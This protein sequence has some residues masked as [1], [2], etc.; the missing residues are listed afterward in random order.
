MLNDPRPT[1]PRRP[2]IVLAGGGH[3]NLHALRRAADLVGSGFDVTLVNPSPYLYYSGMATGTVS[4]D[5]GPHAHRIDVR[6]LAECG[7]GRF[8]EGKIKRIAERHLVL[9]GGG[10]VPFDAASATVGSET[11]FPSFARGADSVF[12]AKPIE[13]L[14]GLRRALLERAEP[15]VLVVGGGAA[16]CEISANALALLARDGKEGSVTLVERGGR[17]LPDAPEGAGRYVES[18]LRLRGARV[19]TGT[20]V[21]DLG[22]GVAHTGDGRELPCDVAVLA[23]G[24]VP[25]TDVFRA[26]GLPVGDDG[27]LWVDG[28]LRSL[29]NGRLFGGGDSISLHGTGLPRLGIF[30]IRQGPVIHH[31]LKAVLRGE[32]LREFRP[33]NRY[34]YVLNLGD[35]TGLAVYGDLWWRGRLA[36]RIKY[37]IDGRF[38]SRNSPRPSGYR[39]PTPSSKKSTK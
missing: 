1:G 23:T 22:G 30:A 4:G 33:Q 11:P 28:S 36:Y 7:G 15:R 20:A 38:V 14:G 13:G 37:L 25:P 2:R 34:L 26:S 18:Y 21:E 32:H 10:A 9:E 3:A 17:L 39:R 31:N 12:P 19:H 6:A 16:G 35:G 29:G 5:Y 8:V 24:V 27:G